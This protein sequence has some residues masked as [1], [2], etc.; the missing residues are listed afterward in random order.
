MDQFT[1]F[2]FFDQPFL[3]DERLLF[4]KF[5]PEVRAGSPLKE[6]EGFLVLG[7]LILFF[8]YPPAN[9]VPTNLLSMIFLNDLV[10][11]IH[12]APPHPPFQD[13]DNT[14]P[15]PM[16]TRPPSRM[17]FFELTPPPIC[18]GAFSLASG[19]SCPFGLHPCIQAGR[20]LP[21]SR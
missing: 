17:Y 7:G 14:F 19:A 1:D 18:E 12:I 4:F 21:F 8:P 9:R 11:D 13:L 6:G 2:F 16:A 10:H 3:V 15:N 20:F 5:P